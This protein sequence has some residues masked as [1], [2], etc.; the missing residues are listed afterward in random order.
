MVLLSDMKVEGSKLQWQGAELCQK[1]HIMKSS[2]Q[3]VMKT[4]KHSDE[5]DADR[6]ILRHDSD[7]ASADSEE[8]D[9]QQ[10]LNLG[11]VLWNIIWKYVLNET[12]IKDRN[13]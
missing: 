1:M 3:S 5:H 12:L 10:S 6:E 2:N 4:K 7:E 13:I 9:N 11:R 8:S